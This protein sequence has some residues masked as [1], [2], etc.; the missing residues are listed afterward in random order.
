MGI[1]VDGAGPSGDVLLAKINSISGSTLVLSTTAGTTVTNAAVG[2]DDTL[3]I[4]EAMAAF[5]AGGAAGGGAI[6]F[7]PGEYVYSQNQSS[8]PN[9]VPFTIGCQGMHFL[10][11]NAR[12]QPTAFVQPPQ[13]SVNGHCGASMNAQ[14]G[15]LVA[16]PNQNTAFENL[17]INGCN[18]AVSVPG[19]VVHFKN[20]T[21]GVNATGLA[22]NTPL[23]IFDT[24]W[25]WF[26]GGGLVTN[27]TT[28]IPTLLMTADACSGCYIGVGNI[29]MSNMILTGGADRI[30][31]AR[32]SER[33]EF[34]A[35]GVPQ[36]YA[37]EW[38]R[39]AHP[40]HR[41]GEFFYRIRRDHA[42]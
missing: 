32:Q 21:L 31:S 28:A 6:Y 23:H 35:L 5:C 4:Q 10:G 12:V 9:A 1:H 37:R 16:Y 8:N 7:P 25:V 30:H 40:D 26:D 41:P 42:G 24:F 29:Y 34:R 39:F 3:A 36:H 13:V 2:D 11:G 33:S 17:I 20:T 27:G 15:F 14:P 22:D 38:Q 18:Q 19:Q